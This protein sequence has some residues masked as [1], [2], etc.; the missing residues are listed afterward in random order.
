MAKLNLGCGNK[1]IDGFVNHDLTKHSPYVD[2]AWDLNDLPWP[3]EDESFEKIA[4]LSVLEH[5]RQRLLDSMNELWRLL[6]PGGVAV[7]K[8]P[9]WKANLTW[10]DLTHLHM[11]GP[12]IMDQ[13]DP[14][15]K[16]GTQYWFYTPRK[17]RIEKQQVNSAKTSFHWTMTKMPLNWNGKD[18]QETD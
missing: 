10:E 16:R 15:T 7:I 3:W 1:P 13:L 8:L 18:G 2:V 14:R 12:G 9:F 11:V 17:W 5:L 6:A 4:A